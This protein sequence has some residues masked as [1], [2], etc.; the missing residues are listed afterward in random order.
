MERGC[1][2]WWLAR[3]QVGD[4]RSPNARSR[5]VDGEPEKSQGFQGSQPPHPAADESIHGLLTGGHVNDA[6]FGHHVVD[7]RHDHLSSISYR[8]G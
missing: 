1:E 3:E 7:A 6:V 8:A 4:T 2:R 5:A